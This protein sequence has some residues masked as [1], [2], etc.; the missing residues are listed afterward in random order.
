VTSIPSSIRTRPRGSRG[1]G[2]REPPRPRASPGSLAAALVVA[3][4]L[5]GVPA[6]AR[7]Q[8]NS[9]QAETMFREGKRL[10]AAKDYAAACPKFAEA[11]RLD[12]SSG[13]QLALGLCLEG[14]GKTASAWGAYVTAASLARRD[15]RKDRERAADQHASALEPKLPHVTIEVAAPTAALAGLVVREDGVL[16][17]SAAWSSAPIDPGAHTIDAAAPG[18]KAFAATFAIDPGEKKTVSV[19]VLEDAPATPASASASAPA[20]PTAVPAAST[21]PVGS[22]GSSAGAAP[23][24]SSAPLA[25]PSH[26]LRNT[27]LVVLGVGAAS[28]IA[29]VVFGL[30]AIN[31]AS[32]VNKACPGST[33]GNAQTVSDDQT[34]GTLADASTGTFIAGGACVAVG[35]L[36]FFLGRHPAEEAAT[37]TAGVRPMVGPGFAGLRGAW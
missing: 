16:I 1:T 15:G 23:S 28:T 19:P 10:M 35:A 37:T 8:S 4:S 6:V 32:S 24:E 34:A 36:L 18:K 12:P 7:A 27:G 14:Q 22:G 31:K 20:S 2:S 26:A 21:V 13:V 25:E 33:C 17:G 30:V 5:L 9:A 11:A 29:G 3:C